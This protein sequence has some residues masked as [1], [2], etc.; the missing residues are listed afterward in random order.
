[1][2]KFGGWYIDSTVM[3]QSD[4]PDPGDHDH[5]VFEDAPRPDRRPNDANN[6]LLYA[7]PET[8]LMELAIALIVENC[9][10]KNYGE[11]PLDPTGPALLGRALTECSVDPLA[12]TGR[13]LPLTPDHPRKNF[14]FILPEGRILA[15]GKATHGTAAGDGLAAF[16]AR[17]TNSYNMLWNRGLVYIPAEP[18]GP[19]VL[20]SGKIR[21]ALRR[22]VR[23]L[24]M[25]GR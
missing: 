4:L 24:R 21:A 25:M 11:G 22:A 5:V 23:S 2:H 18:E 15:W 1:L 7:R 10:Q 12:L 19:W 8:K 3:L 14:A 17:G 20:L 6:G 16:Q 13:Y 9:R